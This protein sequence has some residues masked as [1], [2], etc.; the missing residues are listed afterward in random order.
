[1]QSTQQNTHPF[2]LGKYLLFPK[3]L[4][5]GTFG[6]VILAK[7]PKGNILAAKSIPNKKIFSNNDFKQKLINE[8]SLYSKLNHPNIIK[9]KDVI[10]TQDQTYLIIEYC[11]CE[12]L[13]EFLENYNL[14]FKHNPTMTVTQIIFSQII[15]GLYYMSTQKCVHRDIKL[16]NIMIT[17]KENFQMS[18]NMNED[19]IKSYIAQDDIKEEKYDNKLYF[20]I[21]KMNPKYWRDELLLDESKFENH[22][23]NY[24]IKIIDLG[25]GKELSDEMITKSICGNPYGIAPEIWKVWRR[26]AQSYSG[27]KIDLWSLGVILYVFVFNTLPFKGEQPLQLPFLYEQTKYDIPLSKTNSIT[28]EFIDLV[29]GLLRAEPQQRYAWDVVRNHPFIRKPIEQQKVFKVDNVNSLTLDIMDNSQH[30]LSEEELNEY[31]DYPQKEYKQTNEEEETKN[32]EFRK[33][34]IEIFKHKKHI[35]VPIETKITK[36]DKEWSLLDNKII[37]S[38]KKEDHSFFGKILSYFSS[39]NI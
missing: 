24:S 14:I 27:E 36:I 33:Y 4:G 7:D 22:L 30:F 16:D 1:M 9:L 37:E 13:L 21:P 15:E 29:N 18:I 28:V 31:K 10:L 23:K 8:I 20:D 25:L 6:Q 38:P 11:N 2:Y 35:I 39:Y 19:K 17:E 3:D 26:E 34:L 5:K 32:V 12:N